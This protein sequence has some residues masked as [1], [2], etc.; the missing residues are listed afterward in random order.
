[1]VDRLLRQDGARALDV[2]C[3]V[4]WSG[5]ALAGAYPGLTVLGV[6]S[7]E[8]SIMDARMNAAEAGL[9][10]RARFEVQQA[11]APKLPS[12]YD[13][14]FFFESLHDIGHPVEALASLR[15][16]LRPRG[17]V[18][19]MDE[20]A[21]ESF[22]ANGSPF[23]RFLGAGSVLHCLPVGM[24]EADSAATSTLFRPDTLRRYATRGRLFERRDR[25][26]RARHDEVLRAEPLTR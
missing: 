8:A 26:D 13:V 23:E 22:A 11:D 7:D 17:V 12:S 25:P 19:V 3:G 20:K 9:T 5:I 10:D 16:A 4:G 18:L 14:G 6:D 24:S 2:G 21:E 1:M 15:Q